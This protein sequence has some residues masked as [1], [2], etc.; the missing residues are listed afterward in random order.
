MRKLVAFLIISVLM[1]FSVI[2]LDVVGSSTIQPIVTQAAKVFTQR[3]GIPISVG[4]G[5]SG[6][7]AKSAI[8]GSAEIGACSRDLKP[9]EVEAGLVSH[10]IGLDG[11][12]IIVNGKNPLDSITSA[13]AVSIFRGDITNWDSINDIDDDILV[14]SKEEGRSTGE[15]F[16]KF[17]GIVG[18]AP[19][20]AFLI[21]S[22]V[23]DIAF[24]AGDPYA[25][26]YV[27]I[28]SAE[29]ALERGANIKMLMLDG[30]A[31]SIQN[32]Q[33]ETYPLRRAL[34]LATMGASTGITRQFI[35]FILSEEGQG[36]VEENNFIRAR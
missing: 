34:N 29:F 33:D 35:E 22:N 1:T 30:T 36:I 17:F 14:I 18:Q 20:N 10:T 6:F 3:T 8:D 26:G 13:Q 28:G 16:E 23:E 15:L 7:G 21:G 4:G 32:V 31:A 25:I 5:G 11:I 27:S 24:I 19:E 12:A 9:E 2:A